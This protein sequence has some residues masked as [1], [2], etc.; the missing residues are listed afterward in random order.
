M[1]FDELQSS[2]RT[3]LISYL[4]YFLAISVLYLSLKSPLLNLVANL[5]LFFMLS[6]NYVSTWKSRLTATVF[7]Y[8]ILISI[9]AITVLGLQ[10]L[11]LNA[12]FRGTDVELIV[13]LIVS[14][15]LSYMAVLIL[16]NFKMVRNRINLTVLHWMAIFLIPIGTL[17]STYLLITSEMGDSLAMTI[18]SIS[19]LFLIN[20]FVFYL[21]DVLIKSY[22]QKI[23]RELLW[24]Q[25]EAYTKQF[26]LIRQSQDKMRTLRHD[27]KNH[28]SVLKSLVE[29][30]DVEATLAYSQ[31]I[32][33][34][35]DNPDEYARSGN[36]ELDGILNY[37]IHE[38]RERGVQVD[39]NLTIPEHL[40][41]LPFDLSVILGN[42]L[43]N[44]IEAASAV[45]AEKKINLE[46]FFKRNLLHI[47]MVNPYEGELRQEDGGLRTTKKE[48][49]HHGIGLNSVRRSLEKY[50]GAM[51]LTSKDGKFHTKVLL[52]NPGTAVSA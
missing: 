51:E 28:L 24:Q 29:K 6:M 2:R 5:V 8:A 45:K 38:A 10:F 3:E 35:L 41:I 31:G 13:A 15:I 21:Y 43:D 7:M 48:K 20:I 23:E 32:A 44:A 50:N 26:E 19:V 49:E 52:Y 36:S 17:F 30:Q 16:S 4:V 42:L 9:E 22:Q 39:L 12:S 40:A 11:N 46:I 33:E 18:A 37:K 27:M 25:N 34:F 1:F 14:K 47:Q